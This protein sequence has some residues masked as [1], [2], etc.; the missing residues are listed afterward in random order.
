MESLSHKE[1]NFT[2]FAKKILHFFFQ[3][4]HQTKFAHFQFS[5]LHIRLLFKDKKTT[6]TTRLIFLLEDEF[7]AEPKMRIVIPPQHQYQA[8]LAVHIQEHRSE[9]DW[10]KRL[11]TLI[12]AYNATQQLFNFEKPSRIFL[13]REINLPHLLILPKC[14][15]SNDLPPSPTIP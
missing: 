7:E 14:R 5:E 4:T 3:T 15:P 2:S 11:P 12:L 6:S 13:C 1:R 10:E 8:L 9:N